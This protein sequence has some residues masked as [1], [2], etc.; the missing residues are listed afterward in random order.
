MCGS[1][2]ED[3]IAL[4]GSRTR[5]YGELSHDV[6][7]LAS[8][9]RNLGLRRDDQIVMVMADDVEMATSILAAFHAGFVAVPVS[10]MLNGHELDKIVQDRARAW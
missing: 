1:G 5:T 7:S 9:L 2:A 4:I 10:T 8:G 3:K 6:A